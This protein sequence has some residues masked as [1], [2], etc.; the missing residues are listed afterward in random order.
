MGQVQGPVVQVRFPSTGLGRLRVSGANFVM[1]QAGL[2]VRQAAIL[3]MVALV[4]LA[5]LSGCSGFLIGERNPVPVELADKAQIPNVMGVRSWGDE[6]PDDPVA[7]LRQRN[8]DLPR[9]AQD[10]A[11]LRGRPVVDIL[12][13]SGGG[14]DGAFGSGVLVGWTQSGRRPE[15]EIVTGVSAGALIAPFAFL[16]PKYD[17]VLR[18]IWTKYDTKQLV[19]LAGLPGLLG[20]DSLIDTSPLAEL[21]ARYLNRDVLDEIASEYSRGRFLLVL[22][23]NLDAQRPVVWNMGAL[24]ASRVPGSIALFHKIV[25]ASAAIP[26]AFPPVRITV[27][28]NGEKYD[29]LHV[30]GGTTREVFVLP[31]Q[32]PFRAFDRFFPAPP[33][34]RVFVVKNGKMSP[35][36]EAVEQKTLPIAGRAIATLSL[37]QSEANIYRIFRRVQ[38]AGAE[39]NFISVPVTFPYRRVEIFDPIYQTKLFD[40]AREM[41]KTGKGWSKVPPEVI[42]TNRRQKPVVTR[43]VIRS[44]RHDMF[45]QDDVSKIFFE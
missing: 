22:T 20:G 40:L 10:A 19:K 32:A 6:V 26:G 9:P 15:F 21:I 11:R 24:A 29:E 35:A 41:G 45:G 44:P 7:T 34:Y 5:G 4:S 14:A 8:P 31:V 18:E 12:A 37:N 3:S 38:D 27:E 33:I 28:A 43:P 36:Y 39:F 23:T 17:S 16:G 30:D 25:L 1:A 2:R 13:L 42:P